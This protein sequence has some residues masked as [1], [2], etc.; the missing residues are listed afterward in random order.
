MKTKIR[1]LTFL[2]ACVMLAGSFAACGGTNIGPEVDKNKQQIYVY[3]PD[4]GMGYKWLEHFAEEFNAI[5]EN[6]DYQVIVQTGDLDLTVTLKAQLEAQS[7]DINIYFGSQSHITPLIQEGLLLDVSDVYDMKVDGED[8]GDIKSKTMDFDTVSKA[9]AAL[10][11]EGIYGIPYSIGMSGLIFDYKFFVDQGYL[12]FASAQDLD[13]INSQESGAAEI[14]NGRVV[15]AKSFGNYDVGERILTP[16][17][18]GEYGTYDDG[19][20]VTMEEYEELLAR[21]MNDGN[22]PYIYTTQYVG[23]YT[24]TTYN[25][26]MAQSMGYDN[27][28]NF[29]S[30]NGPITD[31]NGETETTLTPATGKNAWETDTIRK[32]YN[33]AVGFYY[34]NIMGKIGNINGVNY[35]ARQMLHDKSYQTTST[36]HKNAQNTFVTDPC[37]KESGLAAFLI[38]GCWWEA[39]EAR[40]IMEGL[41]VYDT[42]DEPRGYGK[43]EYRYYMYPNITGQVMP[44]NMTAMACQDDGCGVLL[45][46]CPDT[47]VKG[48]KTAF[49]AKCKEFIGYTL[50]DEAL[51]YYTTTTGN[52]R[53]FMY[54]LTDEQY[55]SLTPF[56]R[57]VWDITHDIEHVQIIYPTWSNNLNAVRSFAGLDNWLTDNTNVTSVSYKTPYDAFKSTDRPLTLEEYLNGVYGNINKEYDRLYSV[58]E[59]FYQADEQ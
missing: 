45:N 34:K 41:S 36:S 12:D 21:I 50:R 55:N 2:L 59:G 38:D 43:R 46:N 54:E 25:A 7:T 56:Q 40:S 3:A 14:K 30:L 33:D 31:N 32:A 1:L 5:P 20:A 18:D 13:I 23:A 57:N 58:V 10:D 42:P 29:M 39:N 8:K 11:K 44:E 28:I 52:P 49:I 22:Y 37:V 27:Y 53:P 48:D 16:G 51:Q 17:K 9:F 24:P 35:S 26:L 6:A 4:T 47:Y 15:A 19:Q